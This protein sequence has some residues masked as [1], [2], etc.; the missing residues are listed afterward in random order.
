MRNHP[1]NQHNCMN[2]IRGNIRDLLQ[3]T[4]DDHINKDNRNRVSQ[5]LVDILNVVGSFKRPLVERHATLT[6]NGIITCATR[7]VV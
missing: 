4:T 7:G 6:G 1:G 5:N 3:A 2:T